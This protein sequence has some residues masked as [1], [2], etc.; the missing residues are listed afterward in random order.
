[1]PGDRTFKSLGSSL[2]AQVSQLIRHEVRLMQAEASEKASQAQSGAMSVAVGLLLALAALL[3]L[4]QAV[5][6]GLTHVMPAWA[7]SVCVGVVVGAI[8]FAFV[9]HGRA[10]LRA[11]HFV[12]ERTIRAMRDNKETFVERAT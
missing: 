8:G 5:V 10:S 2:I 6:I 4:L 1:M 7:A 12:P 9:R 11:T 3:I